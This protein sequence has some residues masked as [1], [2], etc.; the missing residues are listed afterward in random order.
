[1]P[2]PCAGSSGRDLLTEI[3]TAAAE[4]KERERKRKADMLAKEALQ[5]PGGREVEGGLCCGTSPH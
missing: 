2:F 4:E 1:M 5:V 3:W